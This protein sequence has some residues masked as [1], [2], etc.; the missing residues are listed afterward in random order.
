MRGSPLILTLSALLLA[1]PAAALAAPRGAAARLQQVEDRFE[2]QRLLI[3]YGRDLDARDWTAFSEL[4]AQK[5]EWVGGFGVVTG[6]QAIHDTMV[7]AIGTKPG[8]N[9]HI[10][11]NFEVDFT[12]PDT[13]KAWSRWSFVGVTADNK[14]ALLMGGHYDDILVREHGRWRFLRREAPADV[15]ANLPTGAAAAK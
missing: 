13:A 4:F 11:T 6:P 5:G 12:G 10:L 2:I 9:Y 8:A 14:P 7:K 1:G 15:P 3:D